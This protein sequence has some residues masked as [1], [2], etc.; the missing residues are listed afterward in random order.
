MDLFHK[1]ILFEIANSVNP[2]QTASSG[3]VLSVSALFTQSIEKSW[4]IKLGQLPQNYGFCCLLTQL[5][6]VTFHINP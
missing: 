6:F 2:D 5:K 4:N 1:K 3:T